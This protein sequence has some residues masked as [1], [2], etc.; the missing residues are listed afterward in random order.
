MS[1]DRVLIRG[2]SLW[3]DQEWQQLD[4]Q[5]SA[6][7]IVAVAECLPYEGGATIDAG[8]L[9]MLPGV[10]DAHVHF[11][12]PGL[13]HKEDFISGSMAAVAGGVTSVLEMPNSRP[14]TTMGS[15]LQDKL[16]RAAGRMACDYAFFVGAAADNL[17]QL[18]DLEQM[19]G[20]AGIKI[21]MGSST[22]NLLLD[23]GAMLRAA[24][25]AGCRRVAVHAED[26]GRLRKLQADEPEPE[27]VS[28]HPFLRD[29]RAAEIATE[30]LIR[31]V[32]ETQRPAH[33]LHVSTAGEV[34][35]LRRERN[36]PL[37]TAEVTPQHLLLE[38]PQ[39][40]I[41]L[42]TRAQMNPPI[43]EAEHR[44]ALWCGLHDGVFQTMGSDHAPHTL[45]EKARPY[46]TS[47]S[48]MPGVETMLPLM[49][50]CMLREELSPDIVIRLLCSGPA[51]VWRIQHK[52]SLHP[53]NDA[54]LVLV[55]PKAEYTVKASR[56][57]SR[58]GWSAFE[59]RQLRGRIVRTIL[60][61]M[62]VYHE[63]DFPVDPMGKVLRFEE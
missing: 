29:E 54:D 4:L 1:F 10:I 33:L 27:N 52:G 12:E 28:R 49:L 11:R 6:G 8:G 24:L 2:A 15:A 30:R 45:E 51:A 34:E 42:G 38:A 46:P 17:Q 18:A 31:L 62:T 14:P 58:A 43:R 39:C 13:E 50:D 59:G 53:G 44:R 32:R 41:S 40:Y 19:A 20:C 22:G 55:D 60:R 3:S 25:R 61:G 36:N 7:K 23:D 63:G 37:L 47:P 48:G 5:I 21:F 9:L 57:H 35:L 16:A 26:E 56:L